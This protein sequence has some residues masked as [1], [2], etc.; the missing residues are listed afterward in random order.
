MANE[1]KDF[2]IKIR[3]NEAFYRALVL[4]LRYAQKLGQWGSSRTVGIYC[5]G[6]GS[7]HIRGLEVSKAVPATDKGVISSA[8]AREIER[9][10]GEGDFWLD[11][12][13]VFSGV[14]G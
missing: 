2:T 14:D 8:E 13:G 7:D 4:M 9:K 5:D 3:C 1:M 10:W 11:T 6:D 12:D